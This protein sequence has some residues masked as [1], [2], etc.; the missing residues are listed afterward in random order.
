[1]DGQC[2]RDLPGL[3]DG[4][5]ETLETE[6]AKVGVGNLD[7]RCDLGKSPSVNAVG[8]PAHQ[9]KLVQIKQAIPDS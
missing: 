8:V 9:P 6:E 3:V 7:S 5:E 1:M 4:P 2:N